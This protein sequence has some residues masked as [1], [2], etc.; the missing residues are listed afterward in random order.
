MNVTSGHSWLTTPIARHIWQTRY[1]W[2]KGSHPLEAG[3]EATWHRV[4][5]TSASIEA[6]QIEGWEQRF[7]ALLEGFRF[8]PAG[9]ILAGAGTGRR[10][11]LFNCFVMGL[12]E[13]DMENIF[14]SLKEGALT[15]QYGGGVGYDFST[16][17]PRDSPARATGRIA[18]GPVSFLHIWDTMCATVFSTGARR[19]AMIATLRCDHPDIEAFIDAKRQ[20]GRL[21]HFNLS[22][23]VTDEF[24]QA[25]ETDGEWPLVF[26][27]DSLEKEAGAETVQRRWPGSERAI[28]CRVLRRLPARQLWQRI[29]RSCYST[30]E[31]G[32]LFIDRINQL[33]NLAYREYITTTNPCGEVPLPPYGACN[34]GSV[35]LTRFVLDPFT[36]SARFDLPAIRHCAGRATRL[37]DNVIDCSRF[38]L[39]EQE[40][41][42]RGSRRIGLGLSGL[43]DALIMLGLHYDSEEARKIA[44]QVMKT[45][46]HAAYNVSI[47]LAREKEPF[48]FFDRE[49][50]LASG[51]CSSLPDV[52]RDGIARHGIRNSH[53]TA[54]AP[55][56][57]ISLLAG[58]I[59][60][61]VE[62]VFDFRFR[63]KILNRQGTHD[64]F[65]LEDYAVRLWRERHAGATELPDYFVR[66][67]ELTPRAHLEMQAVLQP[68]V[69]SAISKT[70]NV[71]EDYPF[72]AFQNLYLEAYRH[73]LKGCTA[74]RPNAITGQVLSPVDDRQSEAGPPDVHCCRHERQC[75]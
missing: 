35:N 19:G 12:I 20:A 22:V 62:P 67:G 40:R 5:H 14:D 72:E 50:Y 70:I 61:G 52:I 4:A 1:R 68:W 30:A 53:L 7:F 54:I 36:S 24:M 49:A 42:T 21:R 29:M 57:T 23:Q 34:L 60:S 43:A 38:P 63:R 41:Q 2:R 51:F 47:A 31:P 59:S 73:G 27:E 3:I 69:D 66:A 48:P 56:G 74:F 28:P 13:D 26:P 6:G 15:M 64:T 58:N 16:L 44:G 32:I 9:R 46:C 39:P 18:S 71:P 45:I 17:R 55:A 65:D 10:V 11:T 8:L 33:N 75:D 37:L 25:L